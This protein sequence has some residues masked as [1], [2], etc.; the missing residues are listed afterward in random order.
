MTNIETEEP[1]YIADGTPLYARD[2]TTALKHV[3][4]TK[5]DIVLVHSDIS[6]FGKLCTLIGSFCFP[7]SSM[8]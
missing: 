1:L 7:T 3:G 8:N 2:F 6:V 5:G 4:I